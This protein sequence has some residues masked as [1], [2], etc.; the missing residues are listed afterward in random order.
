MSSGSFR[1]IIALPLALF[2]LLFNLIA[3]PLFA[4]FF[5]IIASPLPLY[6]GNGN[7]YIETYFSSGLVAL[8]NLYKFKIIAFKFAINFKLLNV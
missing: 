4:I 2:S 6:N 7:S 1:K 3:L 5:N 8:T